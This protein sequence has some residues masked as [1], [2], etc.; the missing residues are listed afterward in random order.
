[1]RIPASACAALVLA[2][3]AGCGGDDGDAGA[4]ATTPS[5]PSAQPVPGGG[6]TVAEAK[7]SDVEGPLAV[8][9]N[10]VERDGA[11]R[12]CSAVLESSPPQCGEPSLRLEGFDR[13]FT[14]GERATLV[15]EVRGDAFVVSS[16]SM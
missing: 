11:V 4:P 12:L 9:G 8:A 14:P 1:M 5:P 7:G 15:G 10:L 2:L 13:A 3:A 16:T 6:L